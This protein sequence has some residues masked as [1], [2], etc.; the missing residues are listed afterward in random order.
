MNRSLR[1]RAAARDDLLRLHIWIADE[2]GSDRA[3]AYLERIEMAC[4]RLCAFLL[5]GRAND[6]LGPGLRVLGFERRIAIV[7]C[8]TDETIDILGVY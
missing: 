7:Y 4:Q 8:V 5:I 1:F 6:D 3:V 2:S